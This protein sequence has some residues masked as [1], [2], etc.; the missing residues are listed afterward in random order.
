MMLETI[1]KHDFED[2][3]CHDYNLSQTIL[4]R[5]I[6]EDRKVLETLGEA[7]ETQ[8]SD[9][10]QKKNRYQR[11]TENM[12]IEIGK[13]TTQCEDERK[14]LQHNYDV[15]AGDLNVMIK[16]LDMVECGEETSNLVQTGHAEKAVLMVCTN[17]KTGETYKK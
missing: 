15:A 9:A 1:E 2:I 10:F 11:D 6:E 17:M 3:R 13:W 5:E 7:A 8:K 14:E 16:I 4:L 12:R